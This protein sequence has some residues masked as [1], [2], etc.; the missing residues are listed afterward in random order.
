MMQF[1][2]F[3]TFLLKAFWILNKIDSFSIEFEFYLVLNSLQYSKTYKNDTKYHSLSYILIVK[4]E[5][6]TRH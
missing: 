4:T 3:V 6:E 5:K 1:R 2:P